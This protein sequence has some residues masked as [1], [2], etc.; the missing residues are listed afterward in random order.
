MRSLDVWQLTRVN[1][2]RSR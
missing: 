1:T 2:K